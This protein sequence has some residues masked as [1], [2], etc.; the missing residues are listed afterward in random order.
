MRLQQTDSK[1]LNMTIQRDKL[2]TLMYAAKWILNGQKGR[3]PRQAREQLKDLVDSYE[4][5]CKK[6]GGS[7]PLKSSATSNQRL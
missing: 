7:K 5:E 2:G 1:Q 3:V 6:I 4:T